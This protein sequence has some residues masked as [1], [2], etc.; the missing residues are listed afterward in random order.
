MKVRYTWKDDKRSVRV[1]DDTQDPASG[2]N[3]DAEDFIVTGDWGS[4]DP[5]LNQH[6]IPYRERFIR[7]VKQDNNINA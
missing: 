7:K 5:S 3:E 1:S 6:L 4:L 2:Y